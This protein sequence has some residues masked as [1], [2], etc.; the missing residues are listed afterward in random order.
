MA[1]IVDAVK[2]RGDEAVRELTQRFDKADIATPCV[3]IEVCV[4]R[5]TS[6]VRLYRKQKCN[7]SDSAG[8]A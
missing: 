6:D 8:L 2:A 5:S 1:P 4:K 3:R 7:R